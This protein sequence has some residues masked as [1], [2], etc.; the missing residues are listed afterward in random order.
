MPKG[1]LKEYFLETGKSWGQQ[2]SGP[3]LALTS[4]VFLFAAAHYTDSAQ[5]AAAVLKWS[6]WL[7]GAVAILLIF[8]AQFDVWSRERDMREAQRSKTDAEIAKNAKPE[9]QA[10]VLSLTMIGMVGNETSM[11]GNQTTPVEC[12]TRVQF[13]IQAVNVRPVTVSLRGIKID[14]SKLPIP[15]IFENAEVWRPQSPGSPLAHSAHPD[16]PYGIHVDLAASAEITVKG[17]NRDG[18]GRTLDLTGLK[19]EL[20]D[21]LGGAHLIDVEPGTRILV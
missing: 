3:V 15:A 13:Q 21:A 9:I 10:E 20:L 17:C 2:I 6:A 1:W 7:T 5:Q 11:V 12:S 4:M 19:I 18:I 14:G 16:L 8:V